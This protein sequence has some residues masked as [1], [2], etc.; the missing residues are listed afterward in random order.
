MIAMEM[1]LE[2]S[3]GIIEKLDYLNDGNPETTTDLGI[4][5][6]LAHAHQ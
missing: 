4:T 2:I 1:E 3:R 5:R 6:Y